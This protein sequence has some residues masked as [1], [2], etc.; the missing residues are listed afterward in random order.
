MLLKP[1]QIRR[2]P[3]AVQRRAGGYPWILHGI[4]PPEMVMGVEA[5][6]SDGWTYLMPQ[7]RSR[8]CIPELKSNEK[9]TCW[10]LSSVH[11]NLSVEHGL[12]ISG[13]I[14]PS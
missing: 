11:D 1:G 9:S 7:T 6:E 8:F 10:K 5:H 2:Q 13:M 3:V 12:W 14:R 4:V